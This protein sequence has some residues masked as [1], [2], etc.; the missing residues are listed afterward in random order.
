MEVIAARF[1]VP[2]IEKIIF[3]SFLPWLARTTKLIRKN[4]WGVACTTKIKGFTYI[5]P[6]LLFFTFIAPETSRYT[7]LKIL[8]PLT[9][10]MLNSKRK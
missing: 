6:K 10:S 2:E 1:Q 5:A 4:N 8:S 3:N 7:A 9:F